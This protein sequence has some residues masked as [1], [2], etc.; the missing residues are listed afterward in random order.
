MVL[1][2]NWGCLAM[3]PRRVVVE[4][5]AYYQAGLGL[6]RGKSLCMSKNGKMGDGNEVRKRKSPA[7]QNLAGSHNRAGLPPRLVF[8]FLKSQTRMLATTKYG[9]P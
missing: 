4:M 7:L 8:I 5:K 6:E 1:F 2:V 9:D 3:L